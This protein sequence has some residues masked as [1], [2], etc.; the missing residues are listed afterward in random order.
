MSFNCYSSV[1]ITDKEKDTVMIGYVTSP[2]KVNQWAKIA[3]FGEDNVLEDILEGC[4]IL[5]NKVAKRNVNSIGY[6][7]IE[8]KIDGSG[9]KTSGCIYKWKLDP[10]QPRS[11][12]KIIEYG[13][14][15][16]LDF[17]KTF[18]NRLNTPVKECQDNN[19]S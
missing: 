7:V 11:I 5:N 13:I 6:T 19:S 2:K 8:R 10:F 9:Y 15:K 12:E 3:I 16:S 17:E 1:C 14:T 18:L 4:F